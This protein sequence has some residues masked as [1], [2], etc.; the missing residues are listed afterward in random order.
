MCHC[1]FF[2]QVLYIDFSRKITNAQQCQCYRPSLSTVKMIMMIDFRGFC[3]L[4]HCQSLP[5]SVNHKIIP[6][7]KNTFPQNY[8]CYVIDNYWAT[9]RID[10]ELGAR[11]LSP[12]PMPENRAVLST[13]TVG[14]L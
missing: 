12:E 1:F 9:A 7:T 13:V 8:C 5:S 11:Q 10:S 6:V 3:L 4:K 14:Q 2:C